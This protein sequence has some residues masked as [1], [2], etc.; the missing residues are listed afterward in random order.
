M[1]SLFSPLTVFL[2]LILGVSAASAE[3]IQVVGAEDMDYQLRLGTIAAGETFQLADEK[4]TLLVKGCT[5]AYQSETLIELSVANGS[6]GVEIT[7]FAPEAGRHSKTFREGDYAGSVNA[8]LRIT[9]IETLTFRKTEGV[10]RMEVGSAGDSPRFFLTDASRKSSQE[11]LYDAGSGLFTLDLETYVL[12]RESGSFRFHHAFRGRFINLFGIDRIVFRPEEIL[13]RTYE[14][15]LAQRY[16]PARR[17]AA[18]IHVDRTPP[19]SLI[20][21][22]LRFGGSSQQGA[23]LATV[24]SVDPVAK[25]IAVNP[26]TPSTANSHPVGRWIRAY[27]LVAHDVAVANQY[28]IMYLPPH[29]WTE[30]GEIAGA[31][32]REFATADPTGIFSTIDI[33]A[34]GGGGG[35][36]GFRLR[37]VTFGHD[38]VNFVG[39]MYGVVSFGMQLNFFG[40]T[41]NVG[42]SELDISSVFDQIADE[43]ISVNT[44]RRDAWVFYFNPEALAEAV[45]FGSRSLDFPLTFRLYFDR[46][47]NL[48]GGGMRLRPPRPI[49]LSPLKGISRVG[50]GF[51][52]PSTF[53]IE[54][55]F[56]DLFLKTLPGVTRDFWRCDAH[57]VLSMDEGYLLITTRGQKMKGMRLLEAVDLGSARAT[58]QWDRSKRPEGQ[59]W[60]GVIF[61]G[62]FGV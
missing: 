59:R 29:D 55:R 46:N 34:G 32:A 14:S 5:L 49:P 38:G 44:Y 12:K 9:N 27:K 6:Q 7:V 43:I 26:L 56:S 4:P 31:I 53:E 39:G 18:T 51:S 17:S 24:R 42:P 23:N 47:F 1:K 60:E 36:I 13:L 30:G 8:N 35:E 3:G 21:A 48:N 22:T 16:E 33:G 25:T 28:P 50:G 62:N 41:L 61:N 54:A 11:I 37:N 58:V 15:R 45:T 10:W 57:V 52:R 40:R 19:Q 2:A 20:G